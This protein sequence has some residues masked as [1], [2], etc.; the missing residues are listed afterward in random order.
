MW[1]NRYFSDQRLQNNSVLNCKIR[2]RLLKNFLFSCVYSR[3]TDKNYVE[4]KGG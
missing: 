1:A 3:F 2:F 4:R